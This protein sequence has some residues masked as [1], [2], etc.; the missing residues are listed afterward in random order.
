MSVATTVLLHA[1]EHDADLVVAGGYGHARLR[2]WVL[3]G[4]TREL[5]EALEIPV[6]FSH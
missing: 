6:L 5:L 2:E 3:G 4:A 1:A